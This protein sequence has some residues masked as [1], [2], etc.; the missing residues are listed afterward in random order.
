LADVVAN[1]EVQI[2]IGWCII[3][4]DEKID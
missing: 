3:F 2:G 1:E 4:D